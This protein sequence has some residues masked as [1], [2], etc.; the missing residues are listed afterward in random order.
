[1][2]SQPQ[3]PEF[4]NNSENFTYALRE[5]FVPRYLRNLE[6]HNQPSQLQW[7]YRILHL[8]NESNTNIEYSECSNVLT[9]NSFLASG[10]SCRLLMIFA[11]SLCPEQAQQN[12]VCIPEITFRKS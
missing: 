7:L 1:M 11:N 10:E 12:V 3:N 8:M 2:E 4:R 6:I 5:S 9:F